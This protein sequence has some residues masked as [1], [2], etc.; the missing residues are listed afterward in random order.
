MK[1]DN[2]HSLHKK[3]KNPKKPK[4]KKKSQRTANERLARTLA[5]HL[6]DIRAL[7]KQRKSFEAC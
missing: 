3:Q 7:Q 2:M 5:L 1:L 6:T 4:K